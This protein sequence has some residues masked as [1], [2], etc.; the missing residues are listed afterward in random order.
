[1]SRERVL[2]IVGF[3]GRAEVLSAL[4]NREDVHGIKETFTSCFYGDVVAF[5]L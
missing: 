3:G 1:M 4:R 5:Y 2:R